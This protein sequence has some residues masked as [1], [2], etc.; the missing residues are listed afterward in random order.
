[1]TGRYLLTAGEADLDRAFGCRPEAW[2]PPRYNIAPGQPILIVRTMRGRRSCD[3]VRWGLTPSWAKDPGKYRP[4]LN[5]RAE[6]IGEK[7]AFRGAM[8][9][10]RCLIP[11]SGYYHWEARGDGRASQPWL[12]CPGDGGLIA[13]AGL[14]DP[15]LGADGSEVDGAAIITVAAGSD[16]VGIA[17][18]M[19]A[20]VS[21][22]DYDGWLDVDHENVT[23]AEKMLTATSGGRLIA[24][25]VSDRVNRVE[26]DGPDLLVSPAGTPNSP[27]RG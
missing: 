1:M 6:G 2:F 26:N 20:I 23:R 14:W 10:R 22:G 18:R 25:P 16:I 19:P 3:L 5:A 15:W 21:P 13:L 9:H 17:D 4:F 7:P 12:I 27:P 11:A 24:T 8:R